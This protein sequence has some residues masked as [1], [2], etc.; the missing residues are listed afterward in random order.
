MTPP[1][2]LKCQLCDELKPEYEVLPCT[3]CKKLACNSCTY[4]FGHNNDEL[5]E[6]CFDKLKEGKL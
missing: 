5:C 6:D 4:T 3:N 2:E 1:E